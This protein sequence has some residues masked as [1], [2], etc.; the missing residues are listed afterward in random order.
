MKG[1][2]EM[3]P[4]SRRRFLSISAAAL[5]VGG[6]AVAAAPLYRWQG[7]ALGAEASIT[8]AHPE[9][10]RIVAEAIAEIGR[11]E[12]IFSLYRAESALSRLNRNGSLEAP[13]FELLECLGLCSALHAATGGVFDP[14]VQPLWALYAE[15][16][17]A[18]GAPS[19]EELAGMRP[20]VGFAGVQFDAQRIRLAR[21]GMALTLNGVA[22]G[23]IADRVADRMRAEG[24]S[25]ILVNT[26]ELHAIGKMPGGQGTGWPV[27][28]K[29]GNEILR[30]ALSLRD[31][32]LASSAPLGTVFDAEGRVG[33]ILDP[34]SGRPTAAKWQLVSVTA[35]RAA[36]ADG[37]ST[38]G[39]MLT[40]REM[41]EAVSRFAG[42]R[43]E[44]LA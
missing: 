41:T 28:L 40:R 6:S 21:T 2:V 4:L 23:Y 9:A 36:V 35:P 27:S 33:H 31:R 32:A 25:G 16:H 18:G 7:V 17:A 37:L 39:C 22:Q 24:L 12:D 3:F 19:E 34:R 15:R 44:Y 20:L 42:A 13:P 38:A 43:L 14:T 10:E 26:G 29:A 11:L 5:A 1:K 30:D 8:L